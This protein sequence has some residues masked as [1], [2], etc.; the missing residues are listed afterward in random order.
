MNAP[1]AQSKFVMVLWSP[2][3]QADGLVL[4]RE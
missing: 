1:Q 2:K 3:D 4:T